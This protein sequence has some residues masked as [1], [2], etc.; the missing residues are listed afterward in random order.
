MGNLVGRVQFQVL[1]QGAGGVL[2][3]PELFSGMSQ[4]QKHIGAIRSQ[5]R[6]SVQDSTCR[7]KILGRN[8]QITI[9]V[10]ST[11]VFRP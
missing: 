3:I 7:Q 5:S 1:F 6:S 4:K 2:I 9:T 10:E 8:Q 11:D